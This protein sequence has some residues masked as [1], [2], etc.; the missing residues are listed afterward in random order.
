MVLNLENFLPFFFVSFCTLHKQ[1]GNGMRTSSAK[2]V[3]GKC[4]SKD[5]VSIFREN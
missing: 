4:N 5:F 3:S 2:N 1:K